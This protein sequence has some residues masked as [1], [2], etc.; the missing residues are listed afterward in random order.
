MRPPGMEIIDREREKEWME[1]MDTILILVCP[2]H[3]WC[4]PGLTG[5]QAALFAGF[6]S[7]FLIELLGRLE[8]DPIDII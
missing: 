3:P 7:S 4:Q 1:Q 8:P 5:R 2:T 6:L